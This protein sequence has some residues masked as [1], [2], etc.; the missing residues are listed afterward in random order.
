MPAVGKTFE[1]MRLNRYGTG[2]SEPGSIRKLIPQQPLGT[3]LIYRV[4][5]RHTAGNMQSIEGLARG[6]CVGPNPRNL[7]PASIFVL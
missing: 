7:A 5:C 4:A 3:L 2:W 1:R 6:L